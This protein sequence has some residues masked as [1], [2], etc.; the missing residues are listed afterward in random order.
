MKLLGEE[1]SMDM[2]QPRERSSER[3]RFYDI[4]VR[5]SDTNER[6]VNS[7]WRPKQRCR[8]NAQVAEE[9]SEQFTFSSR[10]DFADDAEK[11]LSSWIVHPGTSC[12]MCNDDA[13]FLNVD[14]IV[15]VESTLADGKQIISQGIE[16]CLLVTLL[17]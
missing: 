14:S 7:R 8:H 1:I 12:H 6:I 16:T 11:I 5:S 4:F 17:G 10:T 13:L 2:Y 15:V 9:S 3:S